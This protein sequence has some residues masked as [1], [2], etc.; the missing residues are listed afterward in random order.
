P[1]SPSPP[2]RSPSSAPATKTGTS[3]LLHREQGRSSTRSHRLPAGRAGQRFDRP[4]VGVV[5]TAHLR[6]Q[7]INYSQAVGRGLA[8]PAGPNK[9]IEEPE[10]IV[11]LQGQLVRVVPRRQTKRRQPFLLTA[12]GH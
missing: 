4:Q 6:Q 9:L 11:E 1:R 2:S 8:D 12:R 5:R 10:P 3:R 7:A